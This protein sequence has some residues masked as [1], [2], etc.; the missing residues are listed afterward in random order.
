MT[1]ARTFLSARVRWGT[2]KADTKTHRRAIQADKNVRA[3]IKCEMQAIRGRI[4]NLRQ[5]V[6]GNKL[7]GNDE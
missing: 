2:A 7:A 6:F 4:W 5:A 1:G 3:P